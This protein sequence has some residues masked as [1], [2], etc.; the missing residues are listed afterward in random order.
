MQNS[1]T[2]VFRG[3]CKEF[4]SNNFKKDSEWTHAVKVRNDS[5]G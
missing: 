5:I 2:P 3:L 1:N 4:K